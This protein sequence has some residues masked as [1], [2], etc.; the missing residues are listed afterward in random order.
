MRLIKHTSVALAAVFVAAFSAAAQSNP[1]NIAALETQTPKSGMTQQYEQGRKQKAD[2]HKQQKDPL[3]LWVFEIL[4]GDETGSYL[5]GRLGQHWA[6]YDKPPIPDAADTEEFN[7]AVGSYVESVK[8][9]YYEYLPKLSNPSDS[10]GPAKYDEVIT[11]RV[12]YGKQGEFRSALTR[13]AEAVQKTKWSVKFE[14]YELASG[15]FDGTYVL[16]LPR[17]TWADFEENPSAKPFREMLK[18]AFGQGEADSIVARIDG[19]VESEYSQI[20]Q[21][22]PDLSYTP[23]K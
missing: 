14:W 22:R 5:V 3:P 19:S 16:A 2:W 20:I 23:A 11:F 1:G 4:S 12:K 13:I 17:A 7:K 18:D 15:G 10:A 8:T 6:D 9:H 21:F